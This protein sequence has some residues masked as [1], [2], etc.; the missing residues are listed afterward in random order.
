MK[1]DTRDTKKCIMTKFDFE[2]RQLVAVGTILL[3]LVNSEI[4]VRYIISKT[5]KPVDGTKIRDAY[6]PVW[7]KWLEADFNIQKH[8]KTIK[9]QISLFFLLWCPRL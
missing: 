4:S 1:Y 6:E 7:S 9:V 3:I 2:M 5:V 8:P